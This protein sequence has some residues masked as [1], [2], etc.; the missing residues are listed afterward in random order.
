MNDKQI[1]FW[2][3]LLDA[4]LLNKCTCIISTIKRYCHIVFQKMVRT[5]MHISTKALN[6]VCFSIS[7]WTL[8]ISRFALYFFEPD[9]IK[10]YVFLKS[11]CYLVTS[12]FN[13]LFLFTMHILDDAHATVFCS[14][15]SSH[16][17]AYLYIQSNICLLFT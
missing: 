5:H 3:I 12:Q 15:Q 17:Y 10:P 16:L 2:D 13:I 7:S 1:Y 6:I 14:F 9:R 4:E 8:D 11:V